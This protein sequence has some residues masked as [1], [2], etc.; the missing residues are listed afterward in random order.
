MSIRN[1]ARRVKLSQK[2]GGVRI[3]VLVSLLT[4]VSFSLS[5]QVSVTISPNT[6]TTATLGTQSFTATVTGSSNTAVTWQVNGVSGG[7]STN[8]LLSTTVPGTSNEAL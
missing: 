7:S 1:F 6:V 3:A 5:A 2:R 8:G 4:L